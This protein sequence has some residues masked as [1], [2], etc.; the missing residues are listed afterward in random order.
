MNAP[1]S[2]APPSAVLRV[3]A[4]ELRGIAEYLTGLA[5]A[6]DALAADVDATERMKV[7]Q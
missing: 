7:P 2:D 3:R 5:T 6:L 4:K 1:L